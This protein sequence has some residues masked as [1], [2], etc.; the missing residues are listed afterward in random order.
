M[1]KRIE[2]QIRSI[3]KALNILM[4][5]DSSYMHKGLE[6]R[7]TACVLADALVLR[8]TALKR[9]MPP[10]VLV[11]SVEGIYPTQM[12]RDIERRDSSV[13]ITPSFQPG[14]S[15]VEVRPDAYVVRRLIR[16]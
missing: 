16:R 4:Y 15:G 10:Q 11:Y 14:P 2:D 3:D 1:G 5:Q 12:A 6:Y 8:R 7:L 9:G 13:I